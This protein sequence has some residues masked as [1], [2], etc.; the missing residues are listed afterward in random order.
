MD[1]PLSSPNATLT[2]VPCALCSK[3]LTIS[4]YAKHMRDQHGQVEG[5][6]RSRV[7]CLYCRKD[8]SSSYIDRH[9]AALHLRSPTSQTYEEPAPRK[10]VK[11]EDE[12]LTIKQ[13]MSIQLQ[14]KPPAPAPLTMSSQL[15][16]KPLPPT[17]LTPITQILEQPV[18][19]AI[20]SNLELKC[21]CGVEFEK[22]IYAGVHKSL[23]I[24]GIGEWY[25]LSLVSATNCS[26]MS[27]FDQ[28][29]KSN[30]LKIELGKYRK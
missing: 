15:Q 5:V 30:R 18:V 12:Q 2:K 6:A 3:V 26:S 22:D 11:T 10:L 9:I 23:M 4:Y 13:L 21:Q 1:R 29:L 8:I 7:K 14:K 19:P 24:S 28:T 27:E 16:K 25:C 17:P 20:A